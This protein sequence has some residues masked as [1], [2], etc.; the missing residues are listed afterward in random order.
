MVE[1]EASRIHLCEMG[2]TGDEDPVLSELVD[3]DQNIVKPCGFR[4]LR[5]EIH[6]DYLER[7]RRDRY[8]A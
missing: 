5:D 8:G 3:N 2:G 6:A 4:Q 1:D 7:V